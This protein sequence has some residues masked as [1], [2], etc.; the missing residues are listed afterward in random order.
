VRN[1]VERTDTLSVTVDGNPSIVVEH[2]VP[3][4]KSTF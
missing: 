2:D 4:K 3:P 1:L